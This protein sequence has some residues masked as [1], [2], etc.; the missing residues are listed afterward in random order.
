[1]REAIERTKSIRGD[2]SRR[3]FKNPFKSVK[4]KRH[5]R[6]KKG[7]HETYLEGLSTVH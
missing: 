7:T 5:R 4:T 6:G 3:S 2:I 1:M